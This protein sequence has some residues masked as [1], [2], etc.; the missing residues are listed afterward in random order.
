MGLP[1]VERFGTIRCWNDP[2]AEC[3]NQLV[4][5]KA[6][7]RFVLHQQNGRLIFFG[8]LSRRSDRLHAPGKSEPVGLLPSHGLFFSRTH[9]L[10]QAVIMPSTASELREAA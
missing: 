5:H 10:A 8:S 9:S 2:V 6:Q 1:N 3:L 4:H 7:T